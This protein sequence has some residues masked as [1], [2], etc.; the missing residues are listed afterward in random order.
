MYL[1]AA[2]RVHVAIPEDPPVVEYHGADVHGRVGISG[3]FPDLGFVGSCPWTESS[4]SYVI[5]TLPDLQFGL[6]HNGTLAIAFVG[7]DS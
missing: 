6:N 5:G 3:D 4:T 7:R 1:Q 2:A